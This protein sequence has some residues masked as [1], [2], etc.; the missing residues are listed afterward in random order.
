MT[1]EVE[2]MSKLNHLRFEVLQLSQIYYQDMITVTSKG[3]ELELVRI[4]TLFTSIDVSCNKLD[5]PI[6]ED[7]GELKSLYIFNLSHNALTGKIPPSLGNLSELESLDLSSN[8]LTG[9]IPTQL[10]Y[11]TFLAV[12]NLSSNQLVGP[13]PRGNQFNTFSK[14]SYEQNEGLCGFPLP[15]RCTA[16]PFEETHSNS[17]I[18]IDWNFISAELGF[19]FGFGIVI[20]PRMFWKRWRIWYYKHIDDI[21]FSIFPQLYLGKEDCQR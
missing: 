18:V 19:V 13:I 15:T 5:G 10:T 4:L 8:M 7:I 9:K 14:D 20:G 1:N 17:G 2:V 12:L 3:L 16:V 21:L 6:P 11:L